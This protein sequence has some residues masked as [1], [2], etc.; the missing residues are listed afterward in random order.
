MIA[1]LLMACAAAPDVSS[2]YAACLADVEASCACEGGD[3][4]TQDID[5]AC[6]L[7]DPAACAAGDVEACEAQEALA[8]ILPVWACEVE[9]Y[10]ATCSPF[11]SECGG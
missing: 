2:L 9:H 7:L 4:C 6:G 5:A 11:G 3:A 10:A 8:P 1:L